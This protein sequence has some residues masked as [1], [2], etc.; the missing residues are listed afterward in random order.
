M[1]Q[2]SELRDLR[3]PIPARESGEAIVSR[4][5]SCLPCVRDMTDAEIE[6]AKQ[7]PEKDIHDKDDKRLIIMDEEFR[8][9]A[10]LHTKQ[11]G[12]HRFQCGIRCFCEIPATIRRLPKQSNHCKR[13]RPHQHHHPHNHAGA[14]RPMP[15]LRFRHDERF[16]KQVFMDM[17]EAFQAY[18]ALPAPM[19][20]HDLAPIQREMWR[21]TA[22]A[23]KRGAITMS[24][25]CLE[26]WQSICYPD[27]S[28]GSIPD[29]WAISSTGRKRKQ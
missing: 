17:R 25:D 27:L 12:Q 18:V 23:Q 19:P 4:R 21:L 9:W 29:L 24:P 5:R 11:G 14:C 6:A 2:S 22:T 8:Q 1:C 28:K 20:E 7:N 3:L 15:L 16:R 10:G 26:Y 13:E